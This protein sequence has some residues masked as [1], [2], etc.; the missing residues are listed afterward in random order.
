VTIAHGKSEYCLCES[1]GSNL[2]LPIKNDANKKGN[3]SIQINGLCDWLSREHY[4]TPRSL[5]EFCGG[6]I[7]LK[8]SEIVPPFALFPIMDVDDCEPN[9]AEAYKNGNLFSRIKLRDYITPIFN[10]PNLDE[11]MI[12]MGYP[13]NKG[14]KLESYQQIY[15]A[16]RGDIETLRLLRQGFSNIYRTSGKTNMHLLL[17]ACIN[18][19]E[20]ALIK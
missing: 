18:E 15:P 7:E 3:S 5:C 12:S 19:A 17:D 10:D 16:N 14:R 8:G 4:R 13:I 1:I 20:K 6:R 11:V 2:H 9:V